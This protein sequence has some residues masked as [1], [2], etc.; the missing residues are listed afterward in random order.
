MRNWKFMINRLIFIL[1]M[2]GTFMG[3]TLGYA[4]LLLENIGIDLFIKCCVTSF[5]VAPAGLVGV[6]L[7]FANTG[8]NT[9]LR[10]AAFL[11]NV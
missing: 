3:A 5:F 8:Y 10:Y 2:I 1:G 6:L 7:S 9:P 11:K 4:K